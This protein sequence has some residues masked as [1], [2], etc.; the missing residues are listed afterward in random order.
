M[1][2]NRIFAPLGLA[3]AVLIAA[4]QPQ[5]MVAAGVPSSIHY[6]GRVAVSGVPFDAPDGKPVS[7]I[8]VLLVPETANEHHLQL[9]SELAQMFSD[10][11]FREQLTAAPDVAALHALFANWAAS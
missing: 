2:I 1:K 6:Q 9:L 4:I 7:L 11:A 10:K 5:S 3:A 8:F